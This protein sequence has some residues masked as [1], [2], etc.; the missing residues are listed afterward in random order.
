MKFGMQPPNSGPFATPEF[1]TELAE[2][3]DQ[4]GYDSL[5]V[6]DHIIIPAE[7]RSRY[8]YNA[9]GV[10]AAHPENDYYEPISLLA[11]LIGRT[12]RIRLGTSVLI[13]PY[14]NPILAAKQLACMDQL[15]GGRIVLGVGVG[16]MEEE[17]R[18]LGS[19]PFAER[20]AVT[21]EYI[22]TFRR[23]WREGTTA[24]TGRYTSAPEIGVNPRPA[25][26]GGIPII[27][28]GITRPAIRR[29][30]RLGDGW[31]PFKLTP[32]EL[33]AGLNYLRAQA[34][35][36][37]RD[38]S[39]F[40]ISLRLSLR[41]TREPAERRPDEEPWKTLVGPARDVLTHLRTYRDLGVTEVVFDFRTCRPEEMRETLRL[42]AEQIIPAFR[43]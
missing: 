38:L 33:I 16:W 19:P 14:R 29:A 3:G 5:Q 36:S 23:I 1:I 28:G 30:A 26:P 10:M 25:Q 39:G 8:P 13:L 32:D 42:C 9:T 22:Q 20:G 17:F 7:I 11:Y 31:Q 27:V 24:L 2:L 37:G 21:D 34:Q 18:I 40:T 41:M 12:R 15:S 43:G 35:R 4:L 6:T